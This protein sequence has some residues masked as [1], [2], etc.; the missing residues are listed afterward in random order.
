MTT[1]RLG[2][3]DPQATG[4]AGPGC[5]KYC[6]CGRTGGCGG[7]LRGW[8]CGDNGTG[9]CLEARTILSE[10]SNTKA[11]VTLEV[12]LP[13]PPTP[14]QI[15]PW[16]A[17]IAARAWEGGLVR[18]SP[19]SRCARGRVL[20]GERYDKCK[21]RTLRSSS[22]RRSRVSKTDA[23]AAVLHAYLTGLDRGLPA[24]RNQE[25][26]RPLRCA[27]GRDCIAQRTG[28][29]GSVRDHCHP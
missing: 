6:T 22:L 15:I 14:C 8:N 23:V 19:F 13:A 1:H 2:S 4:C 20:A 9:A 10:V 28:S 11:A 5:V 25:H 27:R 12:P 24:I 7:Y 26:R 29:S 21:F 3:R 18:N 17:V 16:I